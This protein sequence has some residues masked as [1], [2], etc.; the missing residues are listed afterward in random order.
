MK[1]QINPGKTVEGKRLRVFNPVRR[2][3]FPDGVFELSDQDLRNSEIR[4]LLPPVSGGGIS[5][6]VF[7]DLVVVVDAAPAK[8]AKE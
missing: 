7:G 4:R 5:G 8:K 3:F 2:E 6:G 1:V